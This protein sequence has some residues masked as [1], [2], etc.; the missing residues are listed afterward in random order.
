MFSF[1]YLEDLNKFNE[2]TIDSY[3]NFF[4]S[5]KRISLNGIWNIKCFKN[6]SCVPKELLQGEKLNNPDT[7]EVPSN[8]Q[9]KGFELPQ[10]TNTQ[11]PWDGKEAIVPPQ[12]PKIDNLVAV[13]QK[14]I[15]LDKK[16]ILENIIHLEFEGVETSLALFINGA[17]VGYREDSFATSTFEINK[18]IKEGNNLITCIVTHYCSGSW[19][20]D[21]D[22]WRLSGIFRPVSLKLLPQ[23]HIHDVF[24]DPKVSNTFD[25]GEV[26]INIKLNKE[27]SGILKLYLSDGEDKQD[28]IDKEDFTLESLTKGS[29][30]KEIDFD[31]KK[32]LSVTHIVNN[33]LLYS[34]ETPFLYTLHIELSTENSFYTCALEFGFRKVEIKDNVLYLNN[35]RLVFHGVNRHEFSATKAKAIDFSDIK[36]DLLLMRD[37]N[38]D[39]IRTSHYPNQNIFYNLCNRMGFYVIDETNIES[40]GTTINAYGQKD[41]SIAV[42]HNKK[43]WNKC[44]LDRANNMA[45]RDKNHPSIVMFS[46]GNESSD[47]SN[48][49]EISK[50]LKTFGDRVIHYEN[51]L[52]DSP[53]EA[54]S[55][56]ESQMYTKPKDVETFIQEHPKKPFMLCEYCHAMGNSCGNLEEYT[57]L[58]RKYKNYQGGFI[59]DF[60][61]QSLK[62]NDENYVYA[63]LKGKFPTDADFCC[64]GLV[65]SQYD[66]SFKLKEVKKLYSPILIESDTDS[67][68]IINDFKFKTIEEYKFKVEV[69]INGKVKNGSLIE[70]Y[71]DNNELI[72]LDSEYFSLNLKPQTE[73][74]L[75]VKKPKVNDFILNLFVYD[76][77]NRLINDHSFTNLNL[78]ENNPYFEKISDPISLIWGKD[79]VGISEEKAQFLV[80]YTFAKV[81]AIILNDLNILEKP[82]SLEFW[83]APTNND[84]ANNNSFKWA[85]NKAASLYQKL[86]NVEQG[87]N[88]ATFELS[89]FD[90]KYLLSYSFDNKNKM[91]IDIKRLTND[92]M[93]MPCF[94]ITFA[95]N[96]KYN[97]IKYFGNVKGEAYWDRRESSLL[98]IKEEFISDQ[99]VKYVDPQECAN[100]TDLRFVELLD[101][102]NHGLR[103]TTSTIFEG[104]FL[105]YSPHE[106]EEAKHLED[107]KTHNY[108]TIRIL[109]GQSGIAGDDSWGAPI[110]EQ[111]LYKGI[112]DTWS[113]TFELV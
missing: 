31:N 104:S 37:N 42:P 103:I 6:P 17:Y 8:I 83:R 80:K 88:K 4:S 56:V 3:S 65:T 93:D 26:D 90:Q 111:Y 76:K 72:L 73:A 70:Q 7:I 84:K 21:Q 9:M 109:H 66:E 38:I 102:N 1:D 101:E 13:Y 30:F 43:E 2:G 49:L 96:N 39:S 19:L 87:I 71:L 86:S 77:N 113:I 45:Q 50:L 32:D 79:N 51:V 5:E 33:V 110:H 16:D 25:S 60:L 15:K 14:T 46:C 89:C 48:L 28:K 105:P 94:G 98:G 82:I 22:F 23:E 75:K 10:Y 40:H 57:K 55:D 54:I 35:E 34:H 12:V 95:L 47:G 29:L 24:V 81:N 11:Y 20:E 97:K 62:L 108:N 61:D 106:I 85:K 92:K 99:Y 67:I 58:A 74:L 53:Y 36:R 63:G 68:R 100:K 44:T 64:N 107:L 27:T 59:W 112:E 69:I 52:F 18:F 41:Y 78:K 91:Q